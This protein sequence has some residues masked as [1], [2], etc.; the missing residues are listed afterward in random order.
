MAKLKADNE[1]IIA[2]A[3]AERDAMMKE[4]KEIKDKLLADAR[5]KAGEE[6]KKLITAAKESIQAEKKAA[7]SDMKSQMATLS[8][9]I[10]EKILKTKL[11]ESKAQKDLVTKLVSEA[12]FN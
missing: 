10:A 5:E 12:D 7:I 2:E 4:A 8:V 1:K 9:D 6:A 11:E 3:K